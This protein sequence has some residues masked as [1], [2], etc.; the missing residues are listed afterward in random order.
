MQ[1]YNCDET[2]ESI[3]HKPGKVIAELGRQNVM[4]QPKGG[5]HILFSPVLQH[6]DTPYCLM[7]VYPRKK[8]VLETEKEVVLENEKESG[9][10]ERERSGPRERERKWS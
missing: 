10:R 6:L 7:M 3:V 4:Y 1:V 8:V 5:R 9:P 2:G